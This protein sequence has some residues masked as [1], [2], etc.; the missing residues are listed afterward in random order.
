M[1]K[2]TITGIIL[3]GIVIVGFSFFGRPS[4]KEIA[5][6]QRYADSIAQVQSH[7]I[8]QAEAEKRA[9]KDA[10]F[11]NAQVSSIDTASVYYAA[12]KGT[13]Q[14]ITL[15]N[16][17]LKVDLNTQGG[18]LSTAT[19]KQHK[20]MD[21]KAIRILS[22]EDSSLGFTLY[23]GKEII[24]TRDLFFTPVNASNQSVTMRLMVD[25]ESYIDFNY[26][27]EKD[28]YLLDFSIQAVNMQG[29]LS[30]SVQSI[31]IN[32]KDKARQ[33]E[34]GYD[35]ENRYSNLTW[36]TTDDKSDDITTSKSAVTE[37]VELNTDWIA[38]KNQFF[39]AVMIANQSFMRGAEL[40]TIP[41][42]EGSGY[43]K[44]YQAKVKAQ[45][46]PTGAKKT[47][48]QL[49]IGPNN[50]KILN[51]LP[52]KLED[53][54]DLDLQQLVS[55]GWLIFRWLNRFL[56]I[57]MFDVLSGLGMNMGIVLLVLTLIVK[58]LIFPFTFKSY[59]SS[60]KMRVLK[61][62]ISKI[63]EKYPKKADAM[64]KQQETMGLYR[65]YGVS[66][67]GGCL[68]MLIQFP[69][70]I[71]LFMFVP[72]AIQLRGESFLWAT[73]L[74]TYDDVISW[75]THLPIIGDHI[76]L[77]C[78]LFCVTNILNTHFTM[79]QQD[80][81]QQQQLPA[82]KWMMYLMP[83]MFIFVLNNYAAGLNYYYFISTLISIITMVIL[84][85]TIKDDKI[86]QRL[87]ANKKET[88]QVKKSGFMARMEAM[89]REQERIKQE[90]SKKK[91]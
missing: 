43:L 87:E 58:L 85:R 67:M 9:R 45:F 54:R 24:N 53:G 40:T 89:Q 64:K 42:A 6:Q 33:I 75:G 8:K 90:Q 20:G 11:D 16:E 73:D 74:S 55:L 36:R 49:Y 19:I 51:N 79:Q 56:I 62:Q 41:M 47:S 50:Y 86:L 39:S 66:P 2:N 26:T 4:Q 52:S 1:D 12:T 32:W 72:S 37:T 35:F 69:V 59:M 91:Q 44:E 21:G 27:L 23:N 38:F 77:F 46:D 18:T 78:I 5:L 84:K 57:P 29:K 30:P 68:P 31:D 17:V 81:G 10:Q 28:S 76:S 70:Y 48:I 14:T 63:N 71:A 25:N 61:P 3:I 80:T 83:I 60:A 34:K 15:E 13:N 22:P 7:Q 82:M 65:K 88:V